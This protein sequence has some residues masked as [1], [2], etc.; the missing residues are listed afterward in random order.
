MCRMT[1]LSR[2]IVFLSPLA[3]SP[4]AA[5]DI[6][7]AKEPTGG[8][9]VTITGTISRGDGL[10]VQRL[11]DDAL[12]NGDRVTTLVLNS[13]GGSG[14]DGVTIARLVAAAKATTVVPA[15]GVCSSACFIPWAAG[16]VRK[17]ER[18]ACIGV[19]SAAQ[20]ISASNVETPYAKIRTIDFARIASAYGTP[21]SIVGQMVLTNHKAMYWLNAAEIASMSQSSS[22]DLAV[23]SA[24]GPVSLEP[25]GGATP[26][27]A[28][29]GSP[30]Q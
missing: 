3:V 8:Q 26:Q 12:R 6:V 11:F 1:S 2:V 29:D 5:A 25:G 4:A 21:A 10:K 17:A 19:H 27:R 14:D 7:V 16:V 13:G 15:Q 22:P 30:P 23:R 24:S 18:G 9:V 28:R 20:A